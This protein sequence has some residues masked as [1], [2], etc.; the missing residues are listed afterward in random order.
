MGGWVEGEGGREGGK[1]R[2]EG[3]GPTVFDRLP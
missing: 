1:V 3:K 2:V